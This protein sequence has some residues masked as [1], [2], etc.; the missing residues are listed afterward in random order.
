MVA[1]SAATGCAFIQSAATL[2]FG[3]PDIPAVSTQ[4]LLDVATLN[5]A[6]QQQLANLGVPP[7][8]ASQ[9][10]LLPADATYADVRGTLCIFDQVA[11]TEPARVA[12]EV[13]VADPTSNIRKLYVELAVV[14]PD[15]NP[16][17]VG[18]YPAGSPA[19]VEQ[20]LKAAAFV[21]FVT[22]TAAQAEQIKKALNNQD[23]SDLKDAI[24]QIRFNF[25]QLHF[26]AGQFS[27]NCTSV[28]NCETGGSCINGTC[29]SAAARH[30]ELLSDFELIM[31]DPKLADDP[32]T[33][34]HD[35]EYALVPY[36]L[37][38][39]ISQDT[40][41]RFELDPDSSVTKSIKASV[42]D[43]STEQT[44]MVRVSVEIGGDNLIKVPLD[45]SGFVLSFQPEIVINALEVI[46]SQL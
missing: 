43:T 27:N 23:F 30:N 9:I 26:Q 41:Q 12:V 35:G 32:E 44:L 20:P 42:V 22:F 1:E 4:A 36:F 45:Q 37:L 38:D 46:A 3:E 29:I 39:T 25:S 28:S 24:K 40:R 21:E 6:I 8:V 34:Y 11:G 15:G 33:S 17:Q 18:T 16:Y 14:G 2:I 19:C 13:P 7:T 10:P 5:A 31:A